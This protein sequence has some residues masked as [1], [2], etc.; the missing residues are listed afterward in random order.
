MGRGVRTT[1]TGSWATPGKASPAMDAR[2]GGCVRGKSVALGKTIATPGVVTGGAG[3]VIG[4]VATVAGACAAAS[5]P[6]ASKVT[7]GAR[8]RGHV[9]DTTILK[10]CVGGGAADEWAIEV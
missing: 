4:G 5:S 6:E 2:S 7:R 9:L 10:G 3:D 1:K 8:A